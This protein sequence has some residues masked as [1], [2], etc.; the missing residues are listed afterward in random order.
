MTNSNSNSISSHRGADY[1]CA[2]RQSRQTHQ[3]THTQQKRAKNFTSFT[4]RL[5]ELERVHRSPQID[6]AHNTHTHTQTNNRAHTTSAAATHTHTHIK[7]NQHLL[8]IISS[9]PHTAEQPAEPVS[10]YMGSVET[11]RVCGCCCG[12]LRALRGLVARRRTAARASQRTSHTLRQQRS[13]VVFGFVSERAR[14]A[15]WWCCWL[16]VCIIF[17]L[18]HI[19][20][21]TIGIIV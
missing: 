2:A 21:H 6:Q 18:T 3:H 14:S 12:G 19:Q 17:K 5:L 15:S 13:K 20:P 7:N 4:I 1:V 10:C 8:H 11:R 16:L 9:P